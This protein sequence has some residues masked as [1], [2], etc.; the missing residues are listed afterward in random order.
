[1]TIDEV[2]RMIDY[3]IEC[4]DGDRWGGGE[5]AAYGEGAYDALVRLRDEINQKRGE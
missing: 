5:E 1:M 3:L 2:L 4:Y